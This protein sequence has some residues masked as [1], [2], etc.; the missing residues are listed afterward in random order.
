MVGKPVLIKNG[1]I[2]V[3]EDKVVCGG[4]ILIEDGK[5]VSIGQAVLDSASRRSNDNTLFFERSGAKSRSKKLTV[6]DAGGRVVLP[7]FINPHMHLYSQ[8]AKG[9]N[10]PRMSSFRDILE[11]LWWKLDLALTENDIYYSA[12]LGL[13][14]SIRSGV[15]TVF[16]HHASYGSIKGSLDTIAR[17][18]LKTGVRGSLCFEISD[19]NGAKKR[20]EAIR[21]N[22]RFLE[23]CGRHSRKDAHYPLRGL[24]GLH[25]SMTLSDHTLAESRRE[26]DN[27]G[28]GAHVHVAE[29]VEDARAVKR[30]YNEGILRAG[31]IAA[32]CVHVNDGDLDMLKRSRA[33][34]VHNPQSNL[35]NAVGVAPFIRMHKKKVPV[36]I[37]TD[38]MSASIVGDVKLASVLHKIVAKDPQ[39][40]FMQTKRSAMEINSR[41]A[42]EAFGY[43]IGVL[44]KG[45]AADVVISDYMPQTPLTSSNIW[46]HILYGVMNLPVRTTI[47]KGRILM[48]DFEIKVADEAELASRSVKLSRR[49][50]SRL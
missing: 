34:V 1:Y 50:W 13:I 30:L 17:A 43:R 14:D 32:H 45:A 5:I 37:G 47:C 9:M 10:V 22:A 29:G 33:F 4:C 3:N 7:G 38:G 27:Y 25:A 19:R 39:A 42:S 11:K 8:F 20:D 16:D 26:M 28:V 21:E 35:N 49:L 41:I 46:G 40:G 24:V 31:T 48:K 15:T 2:I 36:G 23:S 6:I 12:L 44:E 18:F